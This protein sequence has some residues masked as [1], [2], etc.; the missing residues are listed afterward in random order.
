MQNTG[1]QRLGGLPWHRFDEET[2]ALSLAVFWAAV[3]GDLRGEKRGYD[4][5]IA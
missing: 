2:K 5:E 1:D 4:H 3:D